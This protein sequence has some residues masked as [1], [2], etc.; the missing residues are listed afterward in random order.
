MSCTKNGN[1]P[2]QY[3]SCS[4]D[5]PKM[6]DVPPITIGGNLFCSEHIF[7]FD[8]F[9]ENDLSKSYLDFAANN[10]TN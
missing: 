5:S 9:F 4:E 6:S 3:I 8:A 7:G 10:S 1:K 2:P